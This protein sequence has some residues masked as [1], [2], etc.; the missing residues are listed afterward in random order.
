MRLA[1]STQDV[2]LP[3]AVRDLALR[4]GAIEG[5]L[6]RDIRLKQSG[7]MKQKLDSAAWMD[8]TATQSISVKACGF[9]WRALWAVW[10]R[11]SPGCAGRGTW[12][13]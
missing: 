7:R 2:R 13:A 3:A 12:P 11:D 9:D 6:P 8:F 10:R 5:K 1:K 4:L